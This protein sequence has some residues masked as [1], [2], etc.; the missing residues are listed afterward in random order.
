VLELPPP[1]RRLSARRSGVSLKQPR[2][3]NPAIAIAPAEA[4]G[5]DTADEV[6]PEAVIGRLV[7]VDDDNV[8]P[9]RA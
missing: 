5:V 9:L 8:V 7:V 3:T 4:E 2:Y 1:D 6:V